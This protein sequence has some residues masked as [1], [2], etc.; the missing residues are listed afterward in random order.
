MQTIRRKNTYT[1]EILQIVRQHGHA[2][3][4]QIATL[5]R[6]SYPRVSDTT[7]HRVTQRLA[8]EGL[9]ARAPMTQDGCLRYDANL[10]LHEHFVCQDCGRLRDIDVPS[11][12]RLDIEATLGGCQITG[13][14]TI[15]GNCHACI[16]NQG[17]D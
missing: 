10:T 9:V 6:E 16:I 11:S 2:T 4:Q 15:H 7:V 1:T 8:D 3:N 12:T 17:K 14:L 5:L 13:K